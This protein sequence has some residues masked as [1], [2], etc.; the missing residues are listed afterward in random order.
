VASIGALIND[1][2]EMGTGNRQTQA[3]EVRGRAKTR[4][5]HPDLHIRRNRVSRTKEFGHMETALGSSP[6]ALDQ[7]DPETDLHKALVIGVNGLHETRRV[8]SIGA[9]DPHV[10]V[11][12]IPTPPPIE[13]LALHA[14]ETEKLLTRAPVDPSRATA[15]STM[16]YQSRYRTRARQANGYMV[17]T[18]SWQLCAATDAKSTN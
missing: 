12:E 16:M 8:L 4:E 2:S 17:P 9:F 6:R 18:P 3:K 10:M 14:T 15:F 13:T 7:D 1:L 5:H 11:T